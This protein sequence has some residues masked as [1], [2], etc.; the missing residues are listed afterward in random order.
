MSIDLKN[1][2]ASIPDYPKKGIIFRDI[3][4]LLANPEALKEACDSIVD[5]A[6]DKGIT[7]VV[8]PEARGFIL[9]SAIAYRIGAGFVPARKPHKLPR[10]VVSA[11]YDLEYGSATLEMQKDA[12]QKGDKVLVMDDLLATGGTIGATMDLVEKLGG[13]VVSAAF[14]IELEGLAGRQILQDHHVDDVLT[15]MKF[16][17]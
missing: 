5:F 6:K 4:P 8:A 11:S 13:Q 2:I 3:M 7:K 15:L 12:I 17:D 10:E 16:A 9:A 14:M 1:Y